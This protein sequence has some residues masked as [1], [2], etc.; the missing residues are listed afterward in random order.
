MIF[1]EK[2]KIAGSLGMT[3]RN[4]GSP[5]FITYNNSRELYMWSHDNNSELKKGWIKMADTLASLAEQF[6][7]DRKGLDE[8]VKNYNAYCNTEKD[9][10]FGRDSATLIPIDTP[11]YY[12]LELCINIINTQGG[13]KRNAKGQV[14]S[15]YETPIPRLYSGGEFGSIWSFLY[16]GACNLS[17]CIFFSTI[18]GTNAAA[19][20]RWS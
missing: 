9:L 7:I 10:E 6:T 8:T 1:D 4:V 16:P 3:E 13:P 20:K 15:P 11:P 17:E 14:M 5:P 19:E 12:G 18:A 2:M